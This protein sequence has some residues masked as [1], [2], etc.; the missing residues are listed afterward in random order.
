MSHVGS[1]SVHAGQ[2]AVT[3]RARHHAEPSS[4]PVALPRSLEERERLAVAW[5]EIRQSQET[6]GLERS[7]A[8][9]GG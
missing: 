3:G 2:E 1:R 6:N 9:F 5:V 4:L 8:S 7:R